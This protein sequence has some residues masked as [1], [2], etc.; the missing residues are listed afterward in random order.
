MDA[1]ETFFEEE[2]PAVKKSS[3]A[4]WVIVVIVASVAVGGA[5][6]GLKKYGETQASMVSARR[7]ADEVRTRLIESEAAKRALESRVASLAEENGRLTAERD[8]LNQK[9]RDSAAPP[10]EAKAA[11]VK[12]T[13]SKLKSW[14]KMTKRSRR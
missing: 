9:L 3:A 12:M 14:K 1:D 11:P 5:I 2:T 4:P 7:E 13:K 8:G 10:P 6:A